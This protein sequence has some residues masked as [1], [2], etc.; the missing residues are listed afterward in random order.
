MG[1]RLAE[2]SLVEAALRAGDTQAL[3]D[4]HR[5]LFG[6]Y[7]MAAEDEELEDDG[8]DVDD[9]DDDDSGDDPDEDSDDDNGAAIAARSLAE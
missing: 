8:D 2:P 3:I 6:G 9:V 1:L 4:L 7:R 5:S